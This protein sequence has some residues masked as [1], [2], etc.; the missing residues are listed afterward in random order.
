MANL[1]RGGGTGGRDPRT[2]GS[3]TSLNDLQSAVSGFAEG[4]G[5]VIQ[6]HSS[7]HEAD[8]VALVY[9][10]AADCDGFFVNPAA[11][12]RFGAPLRIALVEARRPLIE[13]HFSNISAIGWQG[14]Q[15]TP[16]AT[17]VVM[18]LRQYSYLAA[19]FGL[20]CA[21]DAGEIDSRT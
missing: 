21:L 5:T 11:L 15:T 10:T 18:G 4:L 19:V 2:Y 12:T 6:A 1:G 17:A 14:G 3:V 8:L 13:L 16:L 9:E 7:Y 20:I